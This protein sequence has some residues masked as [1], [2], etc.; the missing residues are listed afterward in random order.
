ML[1]FI[2]AFLFSAKLF[3]QT[4]ATVN[5]DLGTNTS[6][7]VTGNVEADTCYWSVPLALKD[8][9]GG[10]LSGPAI[11]IYDSTGWGGGVETGPIA[12][13]YIQFLVKPASGYNFHVDSVAFWLACYGTH[14]GLHAAV[15]WDTDT[16]NFSQTNLLDYDSA[17]YGSIKGLPDVRDGAAGAPHDTSFA[18]NTDV[19]DGGVFAFRVEPWYNAGSASTS[20]YIVMWLV[21]VYGTTSPATAIE[22]SNSL[23]NQYS[24]NQNYPNPFNPSTNISFDL[25]KAGYT[26]LVVYNTLG[27]QVA[28]LISGQ[29]SA[30]HHEVDFHATGLSSGVYFYRL[31]SGNFTQIKKM[32]LLQ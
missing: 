25:G 31:E 20:K 1:L 7:A 30:G 21:R 15:Y 26:K 9:T 2:G 28:T 27:Q 3:A 23:P 32:I 16:A 10:T 22:N 24:L 18:I 13:R 5:W 4:A 12:S 29:L 6:A 11:R 17:S 14:G 19:A 8:F